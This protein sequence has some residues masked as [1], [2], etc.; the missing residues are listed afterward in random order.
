MKYASYD[1][2]TGIII[3]YYDP[4]INKDIPTNSIEITDEQWIDCITNQGKWMADTVN[5][6]LVL[7]PPLPAPGP[8]PP[9]QEERLTAV[10]SAILALMG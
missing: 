6:V 7:A 10:E 3:G 5:K 2:L 1:T 9:T 8:Q 4:V